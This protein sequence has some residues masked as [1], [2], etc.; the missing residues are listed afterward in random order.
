MRT[1]TA[2]LDAALLVA[3]PVAAVGQDTPVQG[4]R[5][6][7]RSVVARNI[8]PPGQ[9]KHLNAAEAARYEADG[10]Q[11]PHNTDQ[12]GLYEDL[13]QAAPT[14]SEA[15]LQRLFKD[16][17]FG[18]PP[19]DVDT[20]TTLRDGDAVIIR[21]RSFGVPHIYGRTRSDAMFAA[22]YVNAQDRLFFMDVLRH[23]GR[24][25]SSALLG[26]SPANLAAD[27]A[28]YELADYTDEERQAMAD[29]VVALD[30]ELGP[31]AK[32]DLEAYVAGVN[33]YIDE[34]LADPSQLPA[35]YA[36]LGRTPRPWTVADS[37]AV[38]T[39][40]GAQFSPGGGGQLVNALVLRRLM[41][42][43]YT[44]DEAR[45]ILSDL[46]MADDPEAPTTVAQRFPFLADLD[47]VDPDAVV[48]PDDPEAVLAQITAAAL[49]EQ[50][51]GPFGPIPLG[52][53]RPAS[54]ALLVSSALSD[55]G[56]ALAVMGPQVGYFS[57][58]VLMEIDIHAPGV[59]ARGATFPGVGLYVL[60]GRGANYAWSATTAYADHRDIRAVEL[61]EPDGSEPTLDSQ[62]Y[63][64]D[65]RCVPMEVR[66]DTWLAPP[67]PVGIPDL[68][69]PADALVVSVTTERTRH[70]IVQAR[71]TVGGVPY[72]FVLQR[73]SYH[74]EV[75]ATLT[76]T[77]IHDPARIRSIEDLKDAF[78]RY[79]SYSFNW[80]LVYD[81]H[82]GYQLTGHYP[83]LPRG[84]DPDLPISGDRR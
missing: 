82:I 54:N 28:M 71:G 58:E 14:L 33:A 47:P 60:L 77:A 84:V 7:D 42:E 38:A 67:T 53:P 20:V 10:T 23:L 72:A 9:G 65:G 36:A 75:D 43:G 56:R 55:T 51:D 69:D 11:P 61:C 48:I 41:D 83:L 17:S 1:A 4:Y 2:A 64:D 6:G 63:L 66:T 59:H 79:F 31:V 5:E 74:K 73:S 30:P 76:F 29:R 12:L 44:Y 78:R 25:Q 27:R 19:D 45:T 16:A 18:V 13:V 50:V 8:L 39:L 24:G 40:I 15:D 81:D 32:A 46:R 62:H 21:D 34:V 49:P 26:A 80:F 68:T 3:V 57:P 37:V 22:G 70:G 52:G 35:V